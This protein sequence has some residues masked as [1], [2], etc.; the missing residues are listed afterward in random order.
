MLLGALLGLFQIPLDAPPFELTKDRIIALNQLLKEVM[1]TG[2]AGSRELELASLALAL[3][4]TNILTCLAAAFSPLIPLLLYRLAVRL[5]SWRSGRAPKDFWWAF[6]IIALIFPLTAPFINGV[7][8]CLIVIQYGLQ[9]MAFAIP[10]L[11]ALLTCSTIGIGATIRSPTPSDLTP[12]YKGA[13]KLIV[14]SASML[15]LAAVTEASFLLG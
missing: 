4:T 10:E 1:R 5:E 9:V 6:R 8:T 11:L 7:L 3:F 15:G 2:A 12:S 14:A 13:W